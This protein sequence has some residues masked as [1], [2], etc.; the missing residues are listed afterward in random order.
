MKKQKNI[1][2]PT[3]ADIDKWKE[4]YGKV[5]EL[6]I[7]IKFT[8]ED[9]EEFEEEEDAQDHAEELVE[10]KRGITT[11]NVVAYL[12]SPSRKIISMATTVGGKDP[13]K[14][15]ELILKSC[16]LGGDE[17]IQKEDDLFL[18]ANGILGDLIKIKT[19]SLKNC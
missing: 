13:I 5:H 17:R 4:L 2:N 9:G 18:A 16:W 19:A 1:T 10:G 8:T 7:P 6:K 11:T 12:K 14:F 3:Q 15:G